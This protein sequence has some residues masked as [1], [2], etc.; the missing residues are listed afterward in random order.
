MYSWVDCELLERGVKRGRLIH[1]LN[2]QNVNETERL[3]RVREAQRLPC[4]A[5]WITFPT[6]TP[7]IEELANQ[8]CV[9]LRPAQ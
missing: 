9:N 1:I 2:C 5:W 3:F 8:P 7:K 4:L 6:H